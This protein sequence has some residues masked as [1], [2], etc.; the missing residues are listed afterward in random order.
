MDGGDRGRRRGGQHAGAVACAAALKQYQKAIKPVGTRLRHP[1]DQVG[2][3]MLDRGIIFRS[4]ESLAQR[5]AAEAENAGQRLGAATDAMI[6]EANRPKFY[7][8]ALP[9]AMEEIPIP[10]IAAQDFAGVYPAPV[11]GV[12]RKVVPLQL[13]ARTVETAIPGSEP[14]PAPTAF[15]AARMGTMNQPGSGTMGPLYGTDVAPG[16]AR[17]RSRSGRRRP[18]M[19]ISRM[20]FGWK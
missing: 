18:A 2:Q 14:S 5:G 6:E 3:E 17:C 20:R 9:P 8:A 4:P 11:V 10:A 16:G 7:V 15:D 19:R 12:R 1:A 13:P